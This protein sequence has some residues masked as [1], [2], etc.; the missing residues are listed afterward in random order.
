MVNLKDEMQ[1]K[2]EYSG[3]D[4]SLK[5]ARRATENESSSPEYSCLSCISSFR[6]T[7]I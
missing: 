4:D 2:Q 5:G 3:L 7:M 1:D 6:L